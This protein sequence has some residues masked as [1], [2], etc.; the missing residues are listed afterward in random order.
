MNKKGPWSRKTPGAPLT[1]FNVGA[2]GGG[3][4]GGGG[5]SNRGSNFIPKKNHNFRICLPKKNYYFFLAYPNKSLSPFFAT[6]KFPKKIPA[7]FIDQ[8]NSLGPLPLSLKYVSGA[9]GRKTSSPFEIFCL[10]VFRILDK[11]S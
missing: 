2:A 10:F 11:A 6:Q 7:S 1:N 5:G 3:G 4:G 8:K 9:P